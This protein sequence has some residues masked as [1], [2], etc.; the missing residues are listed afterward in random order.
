MRHDQKDACWVFLEH[1]LA[2]DSQR[3]TA[4]PGVVDGDVAGPH[5]LR[6]A[7]QFLSHGWRTIHILRTACYP[8]F[9]S[10]AE[11][12]Q[13]IFGPASESLR[14]R[15]PKEMPDIDSV[16][17]IAF[18]DAPDRAVAFMRCATETEAMDRLEIA[19][20]RGMVS[21]SHLI[22]AHG[23][24]VVKRAVAGSPDLRDALKDLMTTCAVWISQIEQ[25]SGSADKSSAETIEK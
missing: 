10:Y 1:W 13:K 21:W 8:Y 14:D 18:Y 4:H 19:R 5:R 12:L 6:S 24:V 23:A 9:M 20:S 11:M 16:T 7:L 15:L 22:V 17:S 3:A 2:R 25:R